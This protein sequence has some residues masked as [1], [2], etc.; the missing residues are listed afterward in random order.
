MP[1]RLP[2]LLVA[3]SL[4]AVPA[5]ALAQNEPLPPQ[6]TPPPGTNDFDCK[7]PPRHP[8]PVVLVHGTF[9][10]MT[11]SWPALAPALTRLDYCV[12]ALDYG[13]NATGD[14]PKSARQLRT[15]VDQVLKETGAAKVA[16]VGHSQGGMMPRY[17]IKFLDRST[18]VDELVGLSPSN[19]GTTNPGAGPAGGFGCTAC[20]QQA[21]GS[22]FIANLNAGDRTPA[23]TSYTVVQTR[24]DEVVTPF[25]SAFL[26]TTGDGRVTNVLL[27]DRCPADVTDHIG[28]T[29]DPVAFQWVLNA[30]G[31]PGPADPA[32]EPDCSGAGASTYP[33]TDS[34]SGGGSEGGGGP[35]PGAD[36][37]KLV[38]GGAR[39]HGRR[40]HVAIKSRGNAVQK[41][42][43]RLRTRKGKGLGRTKK[44][45]TVQKRRVVRIRPRAKLQRGKRYRLV[46]KG[47][48]FGRTVTKRKTFRLR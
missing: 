3:L 26:P 38:I 41:V 47:T 39:R 20:A 14:I 6:G 9:L 34:V 45:V 32:F 25:D 43:V 36:P 17:L 21:A 15:F 48:S 16:I 2:A 40:L 1:P 10:N 31:R 22:E 46:A 11:M 18:K 24:N 37:G 27:Q 19:H 12:F 30:V 28:I 35:G 5:P 29:Y 33:D 23:P 13:N 8:Y 4:L 7:P 42:V 44:R